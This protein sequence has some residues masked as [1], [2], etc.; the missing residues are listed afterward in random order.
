MTTY[1]PPKKNTAFVTYLS[2]ISQANTKVMQSTPTIAAGDFKVS[3]DGGALANLTT[4]PSVTPAASKMIKIDLSAAEMNGDNITIVCSDAAGSEWCDLVLN[5]QTT[6]RQIDDLAFPTVSGR[7]TDVSATGEVGLDFDNIKDATGAHTLTNITVPIVTTATNL[8][9]APTAGDLTAAMKASVTTAATA[10]TPIAASV[11]GNVGGNVVGSVGSVLGAVGSVTAFSAAAIQSIWDA[12]TA[13]LVGPASI[14][15][16]LTDNINATISS[17]LASAS[18]TIPPTA[19]Q[20]A[21]AYLD[22]ADAIEVGLTPRQAQRLFGAALA[23]KLSGAATV[24]VTIRNAVADS[25]NRIVA[26]VDADGNRSAITYDV[27]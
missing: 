19:D 16:L 2:L 26:T 11:T 17:R 23:G 24:T 21:D 4:L 7:G 10:A 13:A 22:R 27:S 1:F 5:L 14:G 12:L 9:N 18:Y 25:K 3:I 15:K 20:N 6:A 8:T